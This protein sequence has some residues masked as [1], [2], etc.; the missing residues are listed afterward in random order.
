MFKA[1]SVILLT[2]ALVASCATIPQDKPEPNKCFEGKF[3][4]FRLNEWGKP[5]QVGGVNTWIFTNPEKGALPTH[6]LVSVHQV[7]RI[8]WRYCYLDGKNVMAYKFAP[9]EKCYVAEKVKPEVGE[10]LHKLLLKL[11]NGHEV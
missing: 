1:I 9:Q 6:V 8:I 10:W 2:I 11:R 7:Y 3:S 5:Q 4:P